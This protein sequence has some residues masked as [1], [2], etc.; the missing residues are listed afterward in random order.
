MIFAHLADHVRGV[1]LTDF[2]FHI[3]TLDSAG[4]EI[5]LV[6]LVVAGTTCAL[7]S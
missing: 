6:I 3:A 5:V 7:H 2:P 4:I 1:L